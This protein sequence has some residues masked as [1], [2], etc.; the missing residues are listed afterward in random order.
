[1]TTE[2]IAITKNMTIDLN[3]HEITMTNAAANVIAAEVTLMDTSYAAPSIFEGKGTPTGGVLIKTAGEAFT[4]V[5]NG[6]LIVESGNIIDTA[7]NA[8]RAQNGGEIVVNNG[9][10]K[11]REVAAL[12]VGLGSN[13]TINGGVFETEDNFVVGG[14]GNASSAGT[15]ITI[16]GGTFYGHIFSEGY[17]ACG[18]YHPQ[19]G[20]LIVNGGEF[21]IENG[22]GILVRGGE[23]TIND[24]NITTTGNVSGKVGD[25][26]VLSNCYDVCVDMRAAYPA[27]DTVQVD[28]KGGTFIADP[29][30]DSVMLLT[31]DE[32]A[33]ASRLVISGGT[34]SKS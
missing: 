8:L 26:Q 20:T 31:N 7:S 21:I 34:F 4:V 29:D 5:N 1:M 28:I 33:D 30:V 2:P 6:K 12:G 32:E 16:N 25:S 14:N 23:V 22:V 9:Y 10:I 15:T 13:I 27:S 18:I 19:G 24:V 17:I 3:G 11:A